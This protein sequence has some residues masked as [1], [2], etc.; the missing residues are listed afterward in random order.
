VSKQQAQTAIKPSPMNL[1]NSIKGHPAAKLRRRDIQRYVKR[2]IHQGKGY[3]S[4]VYLIEV[5]GAQAIVKDFATAPK[6]FRR[7]VAPFL[8]RREARAL[9][10]LNGTPGV[11]RLYGRI[12]P[13]AITMEYIEGTPLSEFKQGELAPEVF[14]RVQQTID[15]IHARGVAHGDV[16]RRSNLI[17][18]PQGEVFVIDFAAAIIGR[19]PLHPIMNWLQHQMA[20]VDDK[21]LPRLKKAVAPE[22]LTEADWEKLNNPTGLERLARRLL[23]R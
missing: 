18:T 10:Y 1:P 15:A 3:Q 4:T 8:L 23:N 5:E 17:L 6:L 19:R 12:D 21:S 22:L 20:A 7:F 13:L 9:Q 16:K 14:P 11:P 2:I